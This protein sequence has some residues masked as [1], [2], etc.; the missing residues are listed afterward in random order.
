M[1]IYCDLTAENPYFYYD[2]KDY[3]ELAISVPL[4]KGERPSNTRIFYWRDELYSYM[5]YYPHKTDKINKTP[6]HSKER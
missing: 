6:K 2:P 1:P 4:K 5:L 3:E